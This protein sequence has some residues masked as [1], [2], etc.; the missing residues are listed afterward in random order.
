M[1]STSVTG[2]AATPSAPLPY[3]CAAPTDAALPSSSPST[4]RRRPHILL[5]VTGSVAAV[6]W[7]ELSDALSSFADVRVIHTRSSRHFTGAVAEGYDPGAAARMRGRVVTGAAAREAAAAAAR[8]GAEE[9]LP[10]LVPSGAAAAVGPADVP[11]ASLPPR[12]GIDVPPP[13]PEP[14]PL[15]PVLLL[16]DEDEWASTSSP[17]YMRVGTD[18]VLHIELRKWADLLVVAP[19]SANTLAKL[20]AG[21]CDNLLTCVARAWEY[22][23]G[24]VA[25]AAND[26][27]GGGGGDALGVVGA[28]SVSRPPVPLKP[29]LCAPAMN[30]AMWAH[31]LTAAHLHVLT[32]TL[33]WGVVAPVEKRLACGD[34][35]NGAMAGVGD[36]V[37][38][39]RGALG[40]EVGV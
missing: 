2:V 21:L 24:P 17:P 23:P 19:L 27:R 1:T 22:G 38:A 6:K 14:R 32:E 18:P 33:G 3:S 35:G 28:S 12:Q 7:L 31:P 29:L 20:A 10:A 13:S 34:V 30:T 37:A 25:G 9:G 36:V 5:G 26:D 11:D 39:V 8:E 4:P 40:M 15:R 16:T